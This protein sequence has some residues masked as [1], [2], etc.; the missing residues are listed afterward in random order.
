M[1]K[2]LLFSFYLFSAVLSFSQNAHLTMIQESVGSALSSK[3]E[4]Y[5]ELDHGMEPGCF[6]YLDSYLTKTDIPFVDGQA[7]YHELFILENEPTVYPTSFFSEGIIESVESNELESV[8]NIFEP[9]RYFVTY[10]KIDSKFYFLIA[11]D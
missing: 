7:H 5:F 4:Y 8:F 6:N 3:F 11:L 1:K 10:K 2:I 9:T